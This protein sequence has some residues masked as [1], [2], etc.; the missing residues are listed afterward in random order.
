MRGTRFHSVARDSVARDSVAAF[1]SR[2]ASTFR[3][4]NA[5]EVT[6]VPLPRVDRGCRGRN[7]YTPHLEGARA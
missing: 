7:E 6:A 3:Q 2:P 5:G 4:R 1:E